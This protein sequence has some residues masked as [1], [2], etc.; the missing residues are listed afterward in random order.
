M[1]LE[2]LLVHEDLPSYEGYKPNMRGN[3]CTVLDADRGDVEAAFAQA[4]HVFADTFHS[5]GI[6]QGYLE[7]MACVA[8]VDPSGRI[9]VWTST[10]APYQI[11]RR[12]PR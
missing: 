9:N 4:D 6:N 2:I 3:I 12:W 1:T 11:R 8:N 10:Q 7:A 5:Q